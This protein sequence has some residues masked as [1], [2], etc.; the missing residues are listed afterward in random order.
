MSNCV[1]TTAIV[2]GRRVFECAEFRGA[3]YATGL[4]VSEQLHVA[5]GSLMAQHYHG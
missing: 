5:R 2:H 3:G 1:G 4:S